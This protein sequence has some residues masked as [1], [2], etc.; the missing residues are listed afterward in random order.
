MESNL[1]G[2]LDVLLSIASDPSLTE[3]GEKTI[4]GLI[5]KAIYEVLGE[6]ISQTVGYPLHVSALIDKKVLVLNPNTESNEAWSLFSI[7]N[8]DGRNLE[9]KSV[10]R[11]AREY[12]FATDY[13]R[14]DLVPLMDQ[15]EEEEVVMYSYIHEVTRLR[16]EYDERES[17]SG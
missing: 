7:Y 1:V 2:Y 5:Q 6:L 13:L 14:I 8:K 11:M 15:I 4:F 16:M 10:M 12:Q 17:Y 9:L 3:D